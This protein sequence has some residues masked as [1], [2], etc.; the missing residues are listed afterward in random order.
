[1]ENGSKSVQR[2]R[3]RFAVWA[4]FF[5]YFVEMNSIYAHKVVIK[6]SFNWVFLSWTVVL[7]DL[8][9]M[10]TMVF[11]GSVNKDVRQYIV[12]WLFLMKRIFDGSSIY[13]RMN[14]AYEITIFIC[15]T[16]IKP[17]FN[18][19]R[20]GPF[21]RMF[22]IKK[23]SWVCIPDRALLAKNVNMCVIVGLNSFTI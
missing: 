23:C 18:I 16:V 1:M 12:F 20:S 2:K 3:K 8:L 22:L 4:F 17:S 14:K 7:F 10:Y 21:Y 15:N 13:R 11:V 9:N 19:L 5:F 6:V